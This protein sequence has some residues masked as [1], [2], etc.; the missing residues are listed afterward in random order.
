[1]ARKT[2]AQKLHEAYVHKLV[3]QAL[4]GNVIDVFD[5][6]KVFSVAEALVAKG[7]DEQAIKDSLQTYVQSIRKV[8]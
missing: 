8:A 3:G 1:M 2:K 5:I 4:V 7:G 6:T